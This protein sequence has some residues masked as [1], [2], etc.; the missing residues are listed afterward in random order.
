MARKKIAVVMTHGMGEQIP[1]ETLRGFVESAWVTNSAVHWPNTPDD[2]KPGDI[3]YMPGEV[4]GSFE[5]RRITTRWTKSRT[6]ADA[7]GPRVDF[8]EFYWADLAEGTTVQE[9][10]DWLAIL[11]FRSPRAVPKGLMGTWI[12]LWIAATIVTLSSIAA[13]WPFHGVWLHV[14]FAGFAAIV[15]YAMK[16]LISPYLGD[17]ARYVRADPRNIAMR[18]AIRERGLKLLQDIHDSGEYERV[19]FV[20]HSLGTVVAYDVISLF[21]TTRRNAAMVQENEP[22]FDRL[23]EVEIAAHELDAATDANRVSKRL[24][25]REAQRALRLALRS[26]G[27]DGTGRTRAPGEEWLIS[28]LVTLGSPLTHAVFLL[29]RDA[30][31]LREKF[32][33]FLFP[34]NWPQFQLVQTEQR[35]KID[36]RPVPPSSHVLGPHGGLFSYF[37]AGQTW[38]LHHAAPF[39]AV[40]WTNI[41]DPHH[42]I[43][44][45]DVIS[46]PVEPFF[47]AGIIDISLKDLRG[48]SRDFSHTLYWNPTANDPRGFHIQAMRNAIDLIDTP[49]CDLWRDMLPM[50]TRSTRARAP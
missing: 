41:Y 36:D 31:D 1:M 7:K 16:Y 47:G 18:R 40:R 23:R 6:A 4:A 38:S 21:W 46:G 24:V 15:A 43:Y 34:T 25:F 50:I 32:E 19:I 11:L 10:Y 17:V 8:F 28:D 30:A 27:A 29:A 35:Q 3:W 13:I 22:A 12:A 45:G 9:V 33:R 2:E 42:L 49:D 26:G 37:M 39:A 20:A 44:Q 5:L 14:F 48:Q